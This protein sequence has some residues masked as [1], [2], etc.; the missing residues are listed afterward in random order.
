MIA[1]AAA[2]SRSSEQPALSSDLEQDLAKAGGASVLLG[3][4]AGNR[5]DVVSASERVESPV[6]TPKAT[7]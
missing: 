1:A 4:S 6:P 3:G 2:C 7:R 5:V